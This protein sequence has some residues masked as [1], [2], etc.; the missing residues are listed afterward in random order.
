LP[1]ALASA[2]A[3]ASEDYSAI[4]TPIAK[5]S[6]VM[7]NTAQLPEAEVFPRTEAPATADVAK[8]AQQP[9][10]TALKSAAP[11]PRAT[12]Q[13]AAFSIST[14]PG[15]TEKTASTSQPAPASAPQ[16]FVST[17]LDQVMEA[18]DKMTS[19]SGS[20]VEVQVNLADGQQLTVRLQMIQGSIQPVF[21]SASPELRQAIEQNWSGFR[22]GASERGLEISNPVFE[23]PSSQAGF[24]ASGNRNQSSQPDT[25]PSETGAS[26]SL[27]GA[28]ARNVVA[29]TL[30][31]PLTAAPAGS[32]VQMYA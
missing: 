20:H 28:A 9:A 6:R 26:Q 8:T 18:A 16:T 10:A 11:Q 4:G 14:P 17:A 30:P 19:T 7:S 25:K 12:P 3:S 22:T 21:K 31:S 29:P 32:S 27:A 13:P 1:Q 2:Q 24:N 5:Q 23:S 15:F